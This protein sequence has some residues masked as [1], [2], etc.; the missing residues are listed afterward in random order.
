MNTATWRDPLSWHVF[1]TLA[2]LALPL[3]IS[4]GPYVCRDISI[5]LDDGPLPMTTRVTVAC[6]GD[7][8]LTA[9]GYLDAARGESR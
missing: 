5:T 4:C 2:F 9:E 3:L 7:T 8:I 1:V 6:D